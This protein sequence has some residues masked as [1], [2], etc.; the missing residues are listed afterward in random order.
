MNVVE[1]IK[2]VIK[3]NELYNWFDDYPWLTGFL[4]DP[5]APIWFIGEN[6]SL[7]GVKAVDRRS[8]DKTENL[9]WNSH[10]GDRLFRE[11]IT[12]AGLKSGNP[13]ENRVGSV[14]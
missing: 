8:S 5:N 13:E 1:H 11:A 7:K 3:N 10:D 4:G 2:D 6:P 14:L 12:E 9:Q